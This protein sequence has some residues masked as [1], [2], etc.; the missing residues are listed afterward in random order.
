MLE[1]DSPWPGRIHTEVEDEVPPSG[2]RMSGRKRD[3]VE[4][5]AGR[6]MMWMKG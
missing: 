2:N 3:A 5:E 1:V 4:A 6:T